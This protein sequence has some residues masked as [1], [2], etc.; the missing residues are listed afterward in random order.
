MDTLNL[1]IKIKWTLQLP[2]IISKEHPFP[3]PIS[4]LKHHLTV[5]FNF[6]IFLQLQVLSWG[7]FTVQKL[8]TFVFSF[9]A[10]TKKKKKKRIKKKKE[11]VLHQVVCGLELA[12]LILNLVWNLIFWTNKLCNIFVIQWY[13]S[14]QSLE[15]YIYI[16]I[17]LV[18]TL[19]T[20][21]SAT[22]LDLPSS[23]K[24]C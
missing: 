4:K 7:V 24:C 17:L 9:L 22:G 20:I 10:L 5:F 2:P 13:S 12:W 16:Y 11:V 21:C 6:R 3:S 19:S 18:G 1:G 23:F 14:T 8:P 15:K